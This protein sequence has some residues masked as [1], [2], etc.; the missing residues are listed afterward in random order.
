MIRELTFRL[1]MVGTMLIPKGVLNTNIRF[2][3]ASDRYVAV[4]VMK[5]IWGR[6][7][8]KVHGPQLSVVKDLMSI[9]LS[10]VNAENE[11]FDWLCK[12]WTP[13]KGRI[14]VHAG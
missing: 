13:E 7:Q 4:I 10:K 2:D 3:A 9:T 6:K 14:P 12:D 11:E 5:S 8:I 1:K